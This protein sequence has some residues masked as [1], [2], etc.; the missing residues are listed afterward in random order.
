MRRALLTTAVVT[1][2]TLALGESPRDSR[3]AA[4]TV[5]LSPIGGP[6]GVLAAGV[7]AYPFRHGVVAASVG[8]T[9]QNLSWGS[10]RLEPPHIQTAF[11]A[12]ARI[13]IEA[14]ATSGASWTG[15]VTLVPLVGYSQ[16]YFRPVDLTTCDHSEGSC[17]ADFVRGQPAFARWLD[18]ELGVE[19]PRFGPVSVRAAGGLSFRLNPG[20]QT[21]TD[22][23]LLQRTVYSGHI[24]PYARLIALFSAP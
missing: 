12:G 16:G 7:E 20:G 3:L 21:S 17:G 9:Y 5:E 19:T 8:W 14:P 13:P 24:L 23:S 1:W 6:A 18:V 15:G 2:S 22:D 10:D 11:M 4:V